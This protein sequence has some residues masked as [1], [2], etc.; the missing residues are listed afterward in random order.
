M[1]QHY[2]RYAV[3]VLQ[4]PIRLFLEPLLCFEGAIA[5]NNGLIE[6]SNGLI[7]LHQILNGIEQPFHLFIPCPILHKLSG[8]NPP[9][10]G[11]LSIVV[12]GKV[13]VSRIRV[14]TR[15]DIPDGVR[16]AGANGTT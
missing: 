14:M 4:T 3:N 11:L 13:C 9:L 10:T 5:F 12:D 6:S 2:Q 15:E 8:C 7:W 1:S 16:Y